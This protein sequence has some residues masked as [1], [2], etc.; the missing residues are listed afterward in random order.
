[1]THSIFFSFAVTAHVRDH[2]ELQK[3]YGF[4]F[5]FLRWGWLS[6]KGFVG[7]GKGFC[8]F[9]SVFLYRGFLPCAHSR[10]LKKKHFLQS[11]FHSVNL[12]LSARVKKGKRNGRKKGLWDRLK[13][14]IF[15]K[16]PFAVSVY[17]S[18]CKCCVCSVCFSQGFQDYLKRLWK[19]RALQD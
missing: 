19:N 16:R 8:Y 18:I 10:N 15:K 1:M 11:S 7:L 2:W 5:F 9:D 17:A 14:L 4:C 12:S 6:K 3:N 13:H